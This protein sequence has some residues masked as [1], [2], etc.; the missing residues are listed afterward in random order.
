MYAVQ[1]YADKWR[2]L[3]RRK[4]RQ[5]Q[6]FEA[7]IGNAID[8]DLQHNLQEAADQLDQ[9]SSIEVGCMHEQCSVVF[10][11]SCRHTASS[12]GQAA[13][14]ADALHW[15]TS[16][17]V[18][19]LRLQRDDISSHIVNASCTL[20]MARPKPAAHNILATPA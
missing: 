6:A 3:E 16:E 5:R 13:L 8:L 14:H 7:A 18:Q 11:L 10:R 2:S 15:S 19:E 1:A 12:E 9:A 17:G 4:D 20:T